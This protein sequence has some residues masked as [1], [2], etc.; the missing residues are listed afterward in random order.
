MSSIVKAHED[1]FDPALNQAALSACLILFSFFA[2][3]TLSD[4]FNS[5][6]WFDRKVYRPLEPT[7][8]PFISGG[9]FAFSLLLW[10]F[11]DMVV[12]GQEAPSKNRTLL[13]YRAIV[14]LFIAGMIGNGIVLSGFTA[15]LSRYE[16]ELTVET[17][18]GNQFGFVC[19]PNPAYLIEYF[20][21]PFLIGIYVVA[22]AKLG[23]SIADRRQK[24]S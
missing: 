2:L 21:L 12:G 20:I 4:A 15:W 23:F 7:I 16:P 9:V 17:E 18:S 8:G 5:P 24:R 11:G 22:L 10:H 19:S 14:A 3:L 6:E 13:S 1:Q